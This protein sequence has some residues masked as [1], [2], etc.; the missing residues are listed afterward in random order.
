MKDNSLEDR[1][2]QRGKEFIFSNYIIKEKESEA[3][4]HPTFNK[5]RKQR[6]V[7]AEYAKPLSP[8]CLSPHLLPQG[9]F[10]RYSFF[11]YNKC[12]PNLKILFSFLPC[13]FNLENPFCT[14]QSGT[15][16]LQKFD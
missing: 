1:E 6:R 9:H 16:L 7:L 11:K 12:D 2:R 8:N 10:G 15:Y 13:L 4:V 5:K 3:T 14:S